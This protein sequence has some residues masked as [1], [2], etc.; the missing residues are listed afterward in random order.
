[1]D[2]TDTPIYGVYYPNSRLTGRD[3][4]ILSKEP[5][6]Q[7][8]ISYVFFTLKMV[9][10]ILNNYYQTLTFFKELIRKRAFD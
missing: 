3:G 9:F 4:V 5:G 1:M 2:L 7:N 6:F 10:G 8:A